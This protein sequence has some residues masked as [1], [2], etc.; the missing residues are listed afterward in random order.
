LA[1]LSTAG[2]QQNVPIDPSRDSYLVGRAQAGERDAVAELYRL[3]S[4]AIF[5]YFFFRVPD[6]ATAEDLTGE[7][8]LK[9]LEG[10]PRYVDRGY[11]F[12]AWLFR[13]AHDRLVDYHRR[14]ASHGSG[15]LSDRL[16][17]AG[18]DTERS[19]MRAQGDRELHARLAELT[20]EQRLVVQLRFV[21]GYSLQE[22]AAIL[23]KTPGAI[24][25][26]QHRAL[27]QLARKLNR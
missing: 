22:T 8:F 4:P 17:D 13:I 16:V 3:H 27:Q 9:M 19:A 24:K 26:L 23:A 11:P 5:R 15:P 25:A 14:K 20:S 10:L 6:Q 2:K 18:A 12:A 21:E 7:V 1:R